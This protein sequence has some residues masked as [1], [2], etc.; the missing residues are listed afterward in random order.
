VVTATASEISGLVRL[1]VLGP[2]TRADVVVPSRVPVADL[3]P[4]LARAVGVLDAYLVHG[5]YRLV[6]QSGATAGAIL[7][8]GRDLAA[9]GVADGAVLT[10]EVGADDD[11]ARAYDDVV[12]A[13]ADAVE[14]A[15]RPWSQDASR[16]AA[17]AAAAILLGT[18][19]VALGLERSD[20]WPVAA[21]AG[22]LAVLL[23]GGAAVL[24][25]IQDAPESAAVVAWLALP[26]AAVAGLAAAPHD[27]LHRLPLLLAGVAGLGATVLG[28]VALDRHR[29]ALIPAL[30][31]GVLAGAVG[32]F[33]VGTHLDVAA[34]VAVGLVIGVLATT[35]APALA[36]TST[37][38]RTPSPDVT[39]P[40]ALDGPVEPVDAATVG[41]AVAAGRSTLLGFLAATGL[42]LLAGAPF[43][44]HLG[45]SGGLLGVV[46]AVLLLLRTRRSRAAS[47]V[48]VGMT[49]AILGLG[50]LGTAA[51]LA[52]PEWRTALA[53]ALI[54]VGFVLLVL[55]RGTGRARLWVGR[56]GDIAEGA[57]MVAMLPLVVL[58]IGVVDAVQR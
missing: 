58:A 54:A 23:L 36:M 51:A 49:G 33:D 3:L 25:R 31:L 27:D 56:A 48:A 52:H 46:V 14:T 34:V 50:V 39:S 26:P 4:D 38:F 42:L 7:D 20:G 41:R 15:T 18:A 55:A 16:R 53:G 43:L 37:R 47:D 44:V 24:A 2:D 45:T 30:A 10:V 17:L 11:E 32:G 8:P 57:A 21:A 9:Q 22:V 1:I 6:R 35:T 12:E 13:V 19:S 29:A 28:L 40:D 5:G